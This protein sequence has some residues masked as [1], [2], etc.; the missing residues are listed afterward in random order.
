MFPPY[1]HLN[2]DLSDVPSNYAI[3]EPELSDPISIVTAVFAGTPAIFGANNL[4]RVATNILANRILASGATPRYLAATY[5]FDSD[6]PVNIVNAVDMAMRDAA[7][8]AEMEATA[9]SSKTL[10]SGAADGINLSMFGIG[11]RIP[12]FSFGTDN[13]RPGDTLIVSGPVGA[14]GTAVRSAAYGIE[15]MFCADGHAL[16]DGIHALANVTPKVRSLIFPDKGIASAIRTLSSSHAVDIDITGI[17]VDEAV[18][19]ACRIM[20]INPMEMPC[21]ASMLIVVPRGE[22]LKTLEA[23]R[24]SAYCGRAAIIGQI[25]RN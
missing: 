16:T 13:I 18:I 17:P 14:Y 3:P 24:R 8:Q 9:V 25:T 11:T 15:P 2:R 20:D 4:G 23:L 6:I 19:N 21:A 12:G 22:G 7:V 5:T 10:T 1:T